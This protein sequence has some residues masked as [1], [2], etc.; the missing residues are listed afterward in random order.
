M[1]YP[2]TEPVSCYSGDLLLLEL[3]GGKSPALELESPARATLI[4][5][6][7]LTPFD[8]K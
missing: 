8:Q 5:L 2:D 7:G 1:I 4:H 3:S 6:F